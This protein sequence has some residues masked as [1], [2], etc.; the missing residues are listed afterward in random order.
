MLLSAWLVFLIQPMLGRMIL[1][2]LGGAASV[3]ITVSLFFQ[4]ALLVGYFYAHVITARMRPR[5]QMAVHAVLALAAI[6]LLPVTIPAT[7]VPPAD[8]APQGD[9]ILMMA[10]TVGLPFV[11]VSATAPLLQRWYSLTGA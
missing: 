1:P 3:W 7:W 9:L 4:I 5:V 6:F 10:V 8:R 11:V 2:R